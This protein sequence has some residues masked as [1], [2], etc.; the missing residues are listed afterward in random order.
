M[1]AVCTCLVLGIVIDLRRVVRVQHS[2]EEGYAKEVA[3][4]VALDFR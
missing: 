1:E 2:E 4:R 3:L